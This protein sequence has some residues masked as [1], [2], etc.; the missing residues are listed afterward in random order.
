MSSTFWIIGFRYHCRHCRNPRTQKIGTVTW[1]S[2]DSQILA[3]LPPELAAEFPAKLSHRSAMSMRLFSWMRSCFQS[4]MSTK[5]F[6]SAVRVQ[7]LLRYDEL[8]LQYLDFLVS[9]SGLYRWSKR[10]FKSFRSFTDSSED[11][12]H[13]YI[14]STQWFRDLYDNFIEEYRN[15]F[16]QHTAMLTA[17]ICAIDHSHKVCHLIPGYCIC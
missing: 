15:N 8:H 1:R 13:G 5:Q 12:F 10:K 11:G 4:G 16:N 14:P 3:L 17:N 6:A 9:N 2:W 7:H